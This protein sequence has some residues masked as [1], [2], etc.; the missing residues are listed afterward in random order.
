MRLA[1]PGSGNTGAERAQ[2]FT[3]MGV[4]ER[5]SCKVDEDELK[6]HDKGKYSHTATHTNTRTYLTGSGTAANTF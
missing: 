1:K 6:K 2:F 5:N 4:E 3:T